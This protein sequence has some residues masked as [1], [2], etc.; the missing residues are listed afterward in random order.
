MSAWLIVGIALGVLGAIL[1]LV[2]IVPR[3]IARILDSGP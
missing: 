1:L 3:V 2:W